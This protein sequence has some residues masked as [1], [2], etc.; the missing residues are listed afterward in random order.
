MATSDSIDT[1][2]GLLY[3]LLDTQ[4]NLLSPAGPSSNIYNG[5]EAAQ[6]CSQ[7]IDT[8]ADYLDGRDKK[9]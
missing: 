2:T 9:K 5:K 3:K 1:A 7:F 6:F 4:P 8:F